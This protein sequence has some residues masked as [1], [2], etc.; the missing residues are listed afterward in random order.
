MRVTD[1]AK[2]I[3]LT[4]YNRTDYLRQALDALG[5]CSGVEDYTLIVS[6]EP[7]FQDVLDI[8]KS[9][10]FCDV[11]LNINSR[12]LGNSLNTLVAIDYGFHITDFFVIH[13]EDDIIFARDAL[14]MFEACAVKYQNNPHVFSVTAYNPEKNMLSERDMKRMSFRQWFHPWGWGTWKHKYDAI[15]NDWAIKNWDIHINNNLRNGRFEIFPVVSRAQNIGVVGGVHA[16]YYSKEW[17]KKNHMA[18]NFAD[19]YSSDTPWAF[20]LD[21]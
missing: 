13:L 4:T 19:G 16:R 12:V 11:T 18:I 9:V 20:G 15:R 3:T 7:G 2:V 8:I 6:A 17:Y 21:S 14:E 5:R 1:Y 10:N